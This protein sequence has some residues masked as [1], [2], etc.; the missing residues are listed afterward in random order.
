[1][2][3]EMKLSV[4]SSYMDFWVQFP[5]PHKSEIIAQAD[6]SSVYELESEKQKL[7]INLAIQKIKV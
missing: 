2:E 4:C 1:M 5:V 3:L 7:K 6:N